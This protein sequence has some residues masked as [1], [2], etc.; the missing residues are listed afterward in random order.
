MDNEEKFS[1]RKF[2]EVSK[3][4]AKTTAIIILRDIKSFGKYIKTMRDDYQEEIEKRSGNAESIGNITTKAIE[5][6]MDI[7][8][9]F[10]DQVHS[11]SKEDKDNYNNFALTLK[12]NLK[13]VW[14]TFIDE[15][16]EEDYKGLLI[17]DKGDNNGKN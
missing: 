1:M 12:N 8:E 4:L 2:S 16:I 5:F 13:D 9:E 14:H 7:R 6:L 11:F 15:Q 10:G 3:L 17:E